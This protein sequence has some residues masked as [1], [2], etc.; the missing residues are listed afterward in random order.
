MSYYSHILQEEKKSRAKA[1]RPYS[2][3]ILETVMQHVLF[4]A[5]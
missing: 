5:V 1:E 4:A 3:L 2:D